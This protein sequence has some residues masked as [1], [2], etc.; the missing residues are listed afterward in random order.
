MKKNFKPTF[1]TKIRHHSRRDFFVF[2]LIFVL[3]F[4]ALSAGILTAAAVPVSTETEL[5]NAI[6]TALSKVVF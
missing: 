1:K 5:R 2:S 3:M 6:K 4:S